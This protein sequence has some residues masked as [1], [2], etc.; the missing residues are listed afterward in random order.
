[1]EFKN[2]LNEPVEIKRVMAFKIKDLEGNVLKEG[3]CAIGGLGDP[4]PEE[5]LD[6]ILATDP[7]MPELLKTAV[8]GI[9]AELYF[10]KEGSEVEKTVIETI[11]EAQKTGTHNFRETVGIA[12]FPLPKKGD[13]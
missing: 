7:Q 10:I 3:A 1:M 2:S 11:L 4:T 8:G 13:S 5:V 6:Q 9:D 12:G